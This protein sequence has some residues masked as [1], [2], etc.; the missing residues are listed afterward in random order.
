MLDSII[1]ID[2]G[3]DNIFT[4]LSPGVYDIRVEDVCGSIE[5][6]TVNLLDL[7]PV[8]NI[9]NASDLVICSEE[10]ENQA[11]FDFDNNALPAWEAFRF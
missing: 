5:V 1:W 9:G 11:L 7:L 6:V 10:L 3:N 4:D 8:V 2:N